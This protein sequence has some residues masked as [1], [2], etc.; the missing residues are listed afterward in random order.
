MRKEIFLPE[1]F[2]HVYNRGVD[3]RIIFL[4][5]RDYERFLIGLYLFND[6]RVH[7]YDFSSINLRSLASCKLED[8]DL[9]VDILHWCL[10][11]NHFHLFLKQR[12][13]NGIR[14]FMHKLGTGYTK[15][16]NKKHERSGRLYEGSFKARHIDKDDYFSHLGVYIATNHLDLYKT[17]WKENGIVKKEITASKNF[18]LEYKWSSFREY[19]G[20]PVFHGLSYCTGFYEVFGGSKEDFDKLICEYLS[21]GV[22]EKNTKLSF[23]SN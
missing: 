14:S 16:F 6:A 7:D 19:F 1:E 11:P 9:W 12:K 3:K 5:E 22:K 15:Y 20:Q 4:E 8:R 2:Y 10:M 23:V 13:E 18:L 17:S 21:R